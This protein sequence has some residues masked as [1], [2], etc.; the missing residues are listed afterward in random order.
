MQKLGWIYLY[1]LFYIF[2]ILFNITLNLLLD[3]G[4]IT[5]ISR[6]EKKQ[7]KEAA[8]DSKFD[9]NDGE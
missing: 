3:E 2:L 1:F 7:R 5:P 4:W 8:R 9:S 6:R